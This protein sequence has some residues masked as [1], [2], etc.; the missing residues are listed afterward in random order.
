[1]LLPDRIDKR[2][3]YSRLFSY[4]TAT[5]TFAHTALFLLL[6]AIF[7]Y[8]RRSRTAAALNVGIATHLVL[9]F[10]SEIFGTRDA[11]SLLAEMTWPFAPFVNS[12]VPN[13]S[14]HLEKLWAWPVIVGELVGVALLV[15]EVWRE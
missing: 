15:C 7:A 14:S 3:Y 2:L 8:L 12:Y 9:D 1:M 11:L 10:V 13:V 6:M 5:R 4:V